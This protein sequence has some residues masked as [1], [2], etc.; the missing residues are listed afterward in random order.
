ML[1][2]F[3]SPLCSGMHVEDAMNQHDS[4]GRVLVNVNKPANEPDIFLPPQ[5]AKAVH[6]HQVHCI[7]ACTYIHIKNGRKVGK[8]SIASTIQPNLECCFQWMNPAGGKKPNK[9]FFG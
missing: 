2:N 9:K 4:H 8:S 6:P 5:L 3:S 7:L 1:T